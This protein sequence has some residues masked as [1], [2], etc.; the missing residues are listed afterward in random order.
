MEIKEFKYALT[1]FRILGYFQAIIA[2]VSGV[3]ALFFLLIGVFTSAPA[4][5]PALPFLFASALCAAFSWFYFK[6]ERGLRESKFWAWVSGLVLAGLTLFSLFLPL[7]IIILIGLCHPWV[8]P[9]FQSPS[10]DPA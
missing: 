4:A 5:I 3:G 6:V 9:T 1:C 7:S 10:S 2:G 8:R